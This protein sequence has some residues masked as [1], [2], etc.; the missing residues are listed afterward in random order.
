MYFLQVWKIQCVLLESLN[1]DDGVVKET[2]EMMV[3]K[4]EK[5]WEK[6]SVVLALG[7]VLDPHTKL[8]LLEYSYSK[9]DAS[10]SES[11]L[12]SIKN[13]LYKIFEYHSFKEQ[14]TTTT[15]GTPTSNI[16]NEP[17]FSLSYCLM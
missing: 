11:K 8:S 14:N 16:V 1:D 5:Y 10:T 7:A 2:A 12:E 15:Q 6:Y 4:F 13:K 3:A 17:K 9:V